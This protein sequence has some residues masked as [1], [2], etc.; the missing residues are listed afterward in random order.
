MDGLRVKTLAFP[1][2]P[3]VSGDALSYSIAA[4]SILAKVTRDRLMVEFDREFP[5]TAFPATKVTGRRNIWRRRWN[6]S[7]HRRTRWGFAEF[8]GLD[9]QAVHQDMPGGRI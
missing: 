1:Q 6:S 2:D 8:K 7:R 9:A 3:I 4:A 5:A